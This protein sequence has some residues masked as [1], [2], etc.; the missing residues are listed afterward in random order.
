MYANVSD[1]LIFISCQPTF[2]HLR[3]EHIKHNENDAETLNDESNL[4]AYFSTRTKTL[5]RV[6]VE[7]ARI[8][9]NAVNISCNSR[10]KLG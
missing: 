2:M 8:F 5:V 3:N 10:I 7:I 1:D 4:F 6:N 9:V